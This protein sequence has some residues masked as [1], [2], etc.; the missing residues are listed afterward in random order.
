MATDEDIPDDALESMWL[1]MEAAKDYLKWAAAI[2]GIFAILIQSQLWHRRV[3][4]IPQNPM[5]VIHGAQLERDLLEAVSNKI[6]NASVVPALSKSL[7]VKLGEMKDDHFV[8]LREWYC[9]TETTAKT[10]EL[11]TPRGLEDYEVSWRNELKE[12]KRAL[13]YIDDDARF[14]GPRVMDPGEHVHSIEEV[15]NNSWCVFEELQFQYYGFG[16]GVYHTM[17]RDPFYSTLETLSGTEKA[18]AYRCLAQASESCSSFIIR[19]QG[20]HPEYDLRITASVSRDC[21][22]TNVLQRTSIYVEEIVQDSIRF[23]IPYLPPGPNGYKFLSF[24]SVGANAK[25]IRKE[26]VSLDDKPLIQEVSG[27]LP[28]LLFWPLLPTVIG[29]RVNFLIMKRKRRNSDRVDK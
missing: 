19:N 9:R 26:Q 1:L 18:M 16:S 24:R 17:M 29:A 3:V 28:W 11:S 7:G 2:I 15:L 21:V 20:D 8:F 13:G 25:P 12:R 6:V 27:Y 4:L 22:D 14:L 5:I 10:R 23:R